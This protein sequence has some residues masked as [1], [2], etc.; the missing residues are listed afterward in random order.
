MPGALWGSGTTPV[1]EVG[2]PTPLVYPGGGT[3]Y[4]QH[5]VPH[6]TAGYRT[7]SINEGGGAVELTLD[8][9]YVFEDALE[10]WQALA[11]AAGGLAETYAFSY[12]ATAHTVTLAATGNFTVSFGT[13][14]LDDLRKLLGF[15]AWQKAGAASYTSDETPHGF[16][17]PY[18]IEVGPPRELSDAEIRHYRYGRSATYATYRGR[19]RDVRLLLHRAHYEE[20]ELGPLFSG[21]CQC[22]YGDGTSAYQTWLYPLE[23]RE[24]RTVGDA[25][26]L[27]ELQLT[28]LE[29]ET[30]PQQQT[31]LPTG[32]TVGSWT[33]GE[34][35]SAYPFG[36]GSVYSVLVG[37]IPYLWTEHALGSSTPPTGHT[38]V[39]QS[40][41]VDDSGPIGSVIERHGDSAGIGRGYD[42]IFALRDTAE[43]RALMVR[44]SKRARLAVD[45][46][47]SA[48]WPTTLV[49]DDSSDWGAHS[50]AGS[51]YLGGQYLTW[52]GSGAGLLGDELTTLVSV[53][54]RER[55]K[56]K[57]GS[58]TDLTDT[59]RYW[60][61]REVSLYVAPVTGFGTLVGGDLDVTIVWTGYIAE[62]PVRASDGTWR[63]RARSLDRRLD[64]PVIAPIT[65][66][67]V[68]DLDAD[69]PVQL[70]SSYCGLMWRLA[71]GTSA[72][73]GDIYSLAICPFTAYSDGDMIPVSAVKEAISAS[74][75]SANP[76]GSWPAGFATLSD[77]VTWSKVWHTDADGRRSLWWR[78]SITAE[79]NED[80]TDLA[81]HAQHS[82]DYQVDGMPAIRYWADTVYSLVQAGD[83][84]TVP[85]LEIAMDPS[86]TRV[87]R[88]EL[89]D[90]DADSVPAEGWV[91]IELDG[92]REVR[93]YDAVYDDD[94]HNQPGVVWLRLVGGGG[95]VLRALSEASGE[96]PREISARIAWVQSG[97]VPE[98]MLT[99]LEGGGSGALG[100]YSTEA[101]GYDLGGLVDEDSF[102]EAL[103]ASYW[104]L[105]GSFVIDTEA[106]FTRLFGGLLALSG[107]AL[108][109]RRSSAAVYLTAVHA[110][111]SDAGY[112]S[113]TIGPEQLAAPLDGGSPIRPVEARATPNR[114]DAKLHKIASEDS[115]SIVVRDTDSV[116]GRGPVP[117]AVDVYGMARGT[118][119]PVITVWGH[120]LFSAGATAQVIE[121]D[122]YPWI[123]A[124]PGD[125]V[126]LSLGDAYQLW[127]YA[128]GVPGFTGRGRVIGEQVSLASGIRT[129]TVACDGMLLCGAL[130]PSA[131]VEDWDDPDSPDMAWVEV[132]QAYYGIM[133]SYLPSGG[134]FEL[135]AYLPSSDTADT[136]L[137]EIS[138]VTDTGT[139]TRLTVAGN[140]GVFTVT[141]A[142]F[143]TLP[144]TTT[145]NDAQ[146]AYA[147]N[148]M[149]DEVWG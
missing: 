100:S 126:L 149:S 71:C 91:V 30:D 24:L 53:T 62:E 129:L 143:L 27:V 10:E 132:P 147:H 3:A 47:Y 74:W 139:A 75:A 66:R 36:G 68:Y 114:I 5:M 1:A 77:T 51:G 138:A 82:G 59:P 7:M 26:W 109:P 124:Q 101:A 141:T 103:A 87:L 13:S 21:V 34:I 45:Y 127:S 93:R 41:V 40:L 63:F 120:A 121:L 52:E 73:A 134:S 44:P 28:C 76:P 20:L 58:L 55:D 135:A 94:D 6:G 56:A 8:D 60:R 11:N 95:G 31:G 128:D 57:G 122:V 48:G 19:V 32:G 110:G 136:Q 123:E 78:A 72:T 88:V 29:A 90:G 64:D 118:I 49:V 106:S 102:S 12:S 4:I 70:V 46:E 54:G 112:Y 15:E 14:S 144:T 18:G 42:L 67:A 86:A 61:G 33:W 79:A 137:L 50:S 96:A 119:A 80:V 35:A 98:V 111:L 99:L 107:H 84:V 148:D 39:S 23:H 85:L 108:V 145:G 16:C 142:W 69:A 89:D 105:A 83:F 92:Q 131:P 133:L 97:W 104:G 17:Y 146:D 65:G 117:W 125:Q 81:V 2:I 140:T 22:Q 113:W 130:S 9:T 116:A 43:L 37:G 115:G 38:I 25:D